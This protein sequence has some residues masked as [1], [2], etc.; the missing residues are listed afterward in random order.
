MRR[1]VHLT[2]EAASALRERGAE[3]AHRRHDVVERVLYQLA[4]RLADLE[5][6][7][8]ELRG[9]P[10]RD[11]VSAV[12]A[13]RRLGVSRATVQRLVETGALRGTALRL[14]SRA[15]RRW[16]VDGDDLR[17]F[18]AERG[19]AGATGTANAAADGASTPGRGRG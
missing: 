10:A 19:S 1:S 8:A 15:R 14:P 16:V 3:A 12:T 7:V 17:R 2:P 11:R 6:Q 13:A 4:A 5:R 18:E 9:K